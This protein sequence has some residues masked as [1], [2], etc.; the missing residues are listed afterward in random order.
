MAGTIFNMI[1]ADM[2]GR[3]KTI[4][5]G[6][7][8]SAIGSAL[9]GGAVAMSMLMI[10]RFIGG[11]AVGILTRYVSS[12]SLRHKLTVPVQ[13]PCSLLSLHLLSTEVSSP[14]Y[15]NGS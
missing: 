14:V 12:P 2:L 11:V 9:Q 8:V 5:I 4:F 10:G 7:V 15:Y 1:F 13:F 3:K 6:A